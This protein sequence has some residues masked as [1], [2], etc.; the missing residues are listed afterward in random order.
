MRP[1]IVRVVGLLT[2]AVV[3]ALLSG[4][5]QAGRPFTPV[6]PDP[7]LEPWRWRSF[8]EIKGLGLQCMTQDGEGR[9]WFGVD[10]G[11]RVFDG[12]DWATHSD[13][14]GLLGGGASALC[15]TKAGIVYAGTSVGVFRHDGGQWHHVFPRVA[16]LP[17]P[18]LDLLEAAD[19]SLWVA[20]EWGAV[21]LDGTRAEVY[22]TRAA[23]RALEM[24]A[25]GITVISVPDHI[26]PRRSWARGVGAGTLGN[27]VWIVAPGGPA[28]SAGV[29][30]GDRIE[31]VGGRLWTSW[32]QL[33]GPPGTSVDLSLDR[34][35]AGNPLQVSLNRTTM[36]GG[37]LDFPVYDVYQDRGGAVWLGLMD[38]EIV[39]F[40]RDAA[41]WRRYGEEDG[42]A[43]GHS[44]RIIQTRD[45]TIWTASGHGLKGVNRLTP[46]AGP[47]RDGG[48][49]TTVELRGMGGDDHNYS[50]LETADGILWIGGNKGYLHA[51]RDGVWHVYHPPQIPL[52]EAYVSGLL[53][54]ADGALWIAGQGQEAVR[55]DYVTPC[56]TSYE[57][58]LYQCEGPNGATWFLSSDGSVVRRTGD[59]WV[60][61]GRNDGLMG[62]PVALIATG[63]G[64]IWAAGSHDGKASTARFTGSAWT[65]FEH[66]ELSWGIDH[67]SVFEASDGTVWFGGGA[68]YRFGGPRADSPSVPDKL[69]SAYS[70]VLYTAPDG[71]LWVG[72]RRYGVFRHRDGVWSHHDVKDGLADNR[73]QSILQTRDGSVWVSTAKGASRFDGTTWTTSVLPPELGSGQLIQSDDGALWLNQ[74]AT[75]WYSRAMPGF[76]RS[77]AEQYDMWTL[78]YEPDLAPP[79]TEITLSLRE[80]SQPGNTTLAWRGTDPWRSTPDGELQFS[81][82][83]AGKDWSPYS[84]ERSHIFQALAPGEY[85][86][87]VRSR[88]RDFNEDPTPATLAFTV[89]PPVWREPWFIGLMLG[90]TVI[91]AIQ[92][93]RILLSNKWLRDANKALSTANEGMKGA[94]EALNLERDNLQRSLEEL[95]Q[96]Q[97]QLV[98]SEKVAALGRL[99]AGV[100]HEMNTPIGIINSGTNVAVR[101]L[102]SIREGLQSGRSAD[103][104]QADDKFQ[105]AVSVLQEN[106]GV[107]AAASGRLSKIVVGLKS[108]V[109]L[110][111]A[112][113]QKVDLHEGLESTLMLI[114]PEV[115]DRI[116]IVRAFGDLPEVACYPAEM[117]QVFLNLLTNAIQATPGE[118][119][120]TVR[121]SLEREGVQIQIADTGRGIPADEQEGLFEPQFSKEGGR[122]KTSLGLFTSNN[123]IYKHGGEIRVDS[124]VGQGSTFTVVFPANLERAGDG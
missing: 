95:E 105:R 56:W 88:D 118:G 91:I 99:V 41:T 49:W 31:S 17:W 9:M 27:L 12:T 71:A 2:L 101:C 106:V 32:R 53:N 43:I 110:D 22:T 93:G 6:Q 66:P 59:S 5:S 72:H 109:R 90:V 85:T 117:N 111:E 30:V 23:G 26:A 33:V 39:R 76:L 1:P 74:G 48:L 36:S 112:V 121:T 86:F 8:P 82:H 67:R 57:G 92:A 58:L 78:R 94:N 55:L 81:W 25:P 73:V 104:L 38:G 64:N 107:A 45:G 51:Y 70:E 116:D 114:E 37:Y 60:R 28:E 119:T 98:Q 40:D 62:S 15:V 35:G 97:A 84:L 113:F 96:T 13:E 80:V 122:V 108:F 115:R 83:L 44:P 19:G 47:G 61:F 102:R 68:L 54:T 63:E 24:L 103:S 7:V 65:R 14:A 69:A 100:L 3:V 34:T 75:A 18:V 21:R 77:D 46:P 87:Q 50:L 123:I 124:T 79:E 42:L 29:S 10:D 120:I 89:V 4:T 16:G 20:T 52:A 11:V